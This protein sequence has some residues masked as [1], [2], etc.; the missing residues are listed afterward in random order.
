MEGLY[1][2]DKIEGKG[3]G[4]IALRDI[5]AGTLICKEKDQ[6]VPKQEGRV[7]LDGRNLMETFYEMCENDQNE[8][9]N[10]SNIYLDPNS[11]GDEL[12]KE[13]FDLLNIM[14]IQKPEIEDHFD[15]NLL[16]KIMCIYQTNGFGDGSLGIKVSRINHSCC[17]NSQH[18]VNE[19]GETGIRATS[20]ILEGQEISI[21]YMNTKA[22]KNFK[23]RQKFCHTLDFVCSCEICKT[24]EINND[25]EIYQQFQNLKEEAENIFASRFH[26]DD[27]GMASV[28]K[29]LDKIDKVLACRKQMFN[30]AKNKKAPKQFIHTILKEAFG[31]GFN[32]HQLAFAYRDYGKMEYFKRECGKLSKLA[33]QISKM[34]CGQEHTMTKMWKEINQNMENWARNFV[35]QNKDLFEGHSL[36]PWFKNQDILKM[37]GSHC[38]SFV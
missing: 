12:K 1:K 16:L 29:R 38:K 7:F 3:L 6:F 36:F 28:G 30:L 27:G 35:L 5:M 37:F 23:E 22:M 21:S 14:E 17:P 18:F 31:D 25:D 9:L 13:Y 34:F 15:T 26:N 20:K 4:W 32:G 11:L 10:L 8:F 19:E 2:I 24:E 33:Y